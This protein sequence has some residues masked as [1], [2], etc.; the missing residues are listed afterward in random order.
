MERLKKKLIDIV[1]HHPEEVMV[2]RQHEP[3][4]TY[5][6]IGNKRVYFTHRG[7][8]EITRVYKKS[9]LYG[10][11]R[12]A[13]RNVKDFFWYRY[14]LNLFRP[15]VFLP[16][17]WVVSMFY[18][19][20]IESEQAKIHRLET[21]CSSVT[22]FRAEYV[23]GGWVRLNGATRDVIDRTYERF[24]A[25]VNLVGW[26]LG[27]SSEVTREVVEDGTVLREP[28]DYDAGDIVYRRWHEGEI[29]GKVGRGQAGPMWWNLKTRTIRWDDPQATGPRRDRFFEQSIEGEKDID[30]MIVDFHKAE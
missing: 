3:G 30:E 18:F 8:P 14:W 23:G 24:G 13:R 4:E 12:K 5:V 25:E 6:M 11:Y 7:Q 21:F 28:F 10:K 27:G 16:M 29:H 1:T 15:L 20:V 17:L 22:G 2:S 19:G 9:Y 26:L